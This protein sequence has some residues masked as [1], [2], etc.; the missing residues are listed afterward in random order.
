MT[1]PE[2]AAD[3][4]FANLPSEYDMPEAP[5]PTRE[6]RKPCPACGEMIIA[7]AAKCRFCDEILDP[8]AR[9]AA[10]RRERA[11]DATDDDMSTGD[12]IVALLCANIG[13]IAGIVWMIQGKPKGGKMLL[14]SLASQVA[15]VVVAMAAR[16]GR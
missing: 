1:I 8:K 15:W 6:K 10:A 7:T 12:W 2:L 4:E 5:A 9:K 13:C 3:D 11:S 16:G 14:V